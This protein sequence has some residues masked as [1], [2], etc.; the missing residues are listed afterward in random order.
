MEI[1]MRR[2]GAGRK[3]TGRAWGP[4]ADASRLSKSTSRG[5]LSGTWEFWDRPIAVVCEG[6]GTAVARGK[7]LGRPSPERGLEGPFDLSQQSWAR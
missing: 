7:L 5:R 4:A 2:R 6:D 3:I 1:K